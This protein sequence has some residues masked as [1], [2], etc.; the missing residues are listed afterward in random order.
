MRISTQSHSQTR[1]N[2]HTDAISCVSVREV[3]GNTESLTSQNSLRRF[4]IHQLMNCK[5]EFRRSP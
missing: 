3:K 2:P 5:F 4:F 1:Q